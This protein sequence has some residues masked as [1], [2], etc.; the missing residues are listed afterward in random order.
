MKFL[1]R[2]VQRKFPVIAL[3]A[4]SVFL[5][6]PA[7]SNSFPSQPIRLVVP[8][9]PGGFTDVFARKVADAMSKKLGQPMIVE[10]KPGANGSMGTRYVAQSPGD[11]YTI[12]METADTHAINPSIYKD[13]GY[14]PVKDFKQVSFL[15]AQPLVFA[16]SAS[17]PANTVEEFVDLAKKRPGELTYGTWGIGSVSHLGFERFANESGIRLNHVPYKGV[18]PAILDVA[19][20]RVDAIFVGL[21]SAGDHFKT[22]KL[23]ALAMTSARTVSQMPGIEP[24][25]ALGYQDFDINLWYALGVPASTPDAVVRTLSEAA[26]HAIKET[27]I[28]AMLESYS[29][30]VR[31][32]DA[33]EAQSIIASERE[34]WAKAA[35]EANI[36]AN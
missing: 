12:I 15:S 27:D 24:L 17:V 26:Q 16:V 35:T 10:N 28:K 7:L 2:S 25:Q 23:K 5:A 22:G 31:G 19:A 8:W 21:L 20:G 32:T 3:A 33:K 18:S 9:V 1:F 6:P 34:R 11:G 36:S 30:E 14:D 29:M 4:S 13:L